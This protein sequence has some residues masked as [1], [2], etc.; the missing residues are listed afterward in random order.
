MSKYLIEIPHG[1]EKIECLHSVAIL[2]STGSHFLINADWGCLDGNH[3]AWFFMEA[4][5]KA[6]ALR[7]VPPAY[8]KDTRIT[9]LNKFKL[10]DV[11]ELL[12]HHQ[13]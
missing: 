13:A 3:K 10:K 9:Q 1:S 2:Q 6:E 8:R 7:I 12:R 4:G 11:E 5:S